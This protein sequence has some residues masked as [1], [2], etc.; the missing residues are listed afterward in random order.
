MNFLAP[1]FSFQI[2]CTLHASESA[3]DDVP[4]RTLMGSG[5]ARTFEE[6]LEEQLKQASQ[7]VEYVLA[8]FYL[9]VSFACVP[10]F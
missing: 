2:V 9:L 8:K 3:M 5:K 1:N 10:R 4:I 6:L 7:P